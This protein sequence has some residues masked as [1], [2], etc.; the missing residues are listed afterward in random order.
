MTYQYPDKERQGM[1]LADKYDVPRYFQNAPSKYQPLSPVALQYLDELFNFS[2]D[3]FRRPA[4]GYGGMPTTWGVQNYQFTET[5]NMPYTAPGVYNPN[6]P[7]LGMEQWA[8][9][10]QI[11]DEWAYPMQGNPMFEGYKQKKEQELPDYGAPFR[12]TDTTARIMPTIRPSAQ[13]L[14][15]L[16]MAGALPILQEYM[17]MIGQDWAS[18]LDM[19]Q[20]NM[21]Q[22]TTRDVKYRSPR[23]VSQ[24]NG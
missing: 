15:N 9:N 3:Q 14:N 20:S 22:Q 13:L 8:P 2:A 18:T 16:R 21:Q 4:N 23:Q 1:G 6:M 10:P 12:P 17:N 19:W 24:K 7:Q 5:P 11:K